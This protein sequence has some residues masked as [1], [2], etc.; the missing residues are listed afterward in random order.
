VVRE[1]QCRDCSSNSP[2]KE[3]PLRSKYSSI[4]LTPKA[5]GIS[6]CSLLPLRSRCR[7]LSIDSISGGMEPC[8][9]RLGRARRSTFPSPLHVT[10]NQPSHTSIVSA[11]ATRDRQVDQP[12]RLKSAKSVL[13]TKAH[14]DEGTDTLSTPTLALIHNI[15]NTIQHLRVWPL[16][17]PCDSIISLISLYRLYLGTILF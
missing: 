17:I 15:N 8:R 9:P 10:P 7:R 5:I 16:P 12:G 2:K 6:P 14:N 1:S 13:Y 11:L 3:F 4:E